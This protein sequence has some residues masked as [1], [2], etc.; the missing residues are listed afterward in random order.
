MKED[1]RVAGHD[2]RRWEDGWAAAVGE[3][4][5][6]VV[7]PADGEFQCKVHVSQDA[8]RP[9]CVRLGSHK[10][11][12]LAMKHGAVWAESFLRN[13]APGPD[14]TMRECFR[15]WRAECRTRADVMNRLFFSV[16]G[17]YEWLDGS[18]ISTSPEDRAS[19]ERVAEDVLPL[20]P[21]EDSGSPRAFS[22]VSEQLSPIC[23]VP[24]CARPDWLALAY[25]AVCLLASRSSAG[26]EGAVGDLDE[27]R[28]Q[29]SNRRA[30]D[31]V[32]RDLEKRFG[33]AV[34]STDGRAQ[35]GPVEG[36]A[37]N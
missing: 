7:W 2:W 11:R 4:A 21:V 18:L 13:G 25:E 26:E 14:H 24:D 28:A 5:E 36:P 12:D 16:T 17:E 20:G 34:R 8:G 1:R 30:G 22:R 32:K 33:L 35:M 15:L 10:A 19:L 31:R 37:F 9:V 6:V 27:V 23:R 3:R 29:E